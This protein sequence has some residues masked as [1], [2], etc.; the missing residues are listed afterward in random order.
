MRRVVSV[1]VFI[2]LAWTAV[3]AQILTDSNLPIVVIETDGGV[4]IPDEPKVLG[5]MKI[6]W[7]PDGSRNSLEDIDNP[8]YLNYNGRIGIERRG[9]SSQD[10]LNKKPYGLTTLQND[11]VTNNNV[12]LLGMPKENDWI[13][14]NLAFD[15]T[16]M[17]D[18]LAYERSELLGQ[19]TP[20][21]VYCEV[22]VNGDYKGLYVFMEKI[23]I[24]K[25]R[26]NIVKMD[27]T[28]TCLLAWVE[29]EEVGHLF[30]SHES[31]NQSS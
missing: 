29:R 15:Q 12:S 5:T 31:P 20:R 23:K 2:L 17:R 14:N 11:D 30:A 1:A 9:S 24:D 16:G 26:V 10:L 22:M 13:L 25:D 4:T 3:Q 6:I 18:L 21:R 28:C 27:E 19:Y 8:A 7:H